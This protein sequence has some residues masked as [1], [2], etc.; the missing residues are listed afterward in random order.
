MGAVIRAN[1]NTNKVELVYTENRFEY[2]DMP[3]D[4]VVDLLIAA[5]AELELL[6][7]NLRGI[8]DIK[9]IIKK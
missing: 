7:A 9:L 3:K 6:K 5:H 2:D 4:K 8:K 1:Y